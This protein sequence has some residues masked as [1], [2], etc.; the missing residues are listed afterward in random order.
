MSS[1]LELIRCDVALVKLFA[2]QEAAA[3]AAT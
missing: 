1:D 3:K 2:K